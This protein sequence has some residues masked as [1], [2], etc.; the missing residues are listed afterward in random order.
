M[1]KKKKKSNIFNYSI[2]IVVTFIIIAD[3]TILK[4][5]N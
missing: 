3:K 4:F 5:N 2:V 1:L